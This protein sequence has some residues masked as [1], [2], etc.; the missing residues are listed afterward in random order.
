[1]NQKQKKTMTW[2]LFWTFWGIYVLT[3][4]GVLGMLF[5]GFGAVAENERSTLIQY[6]LVET[7]VA[8]IALFYSLFNLRACTIAQQNASSCEHLLGA[9][10]GGW[11]WQRCWNCQWFIDTNE[12]Q[13]IPYIDDKL[14]LEYDEFSHLFIGRSES[15]RNHQYLVKG[16]VFKDLGVFVYE[17]ELLGVCGAFL[18]RMNP[19]DLTVEGLWM[20]KAQDSVGGMAKGKVI[21]KDCES[22]P[23]FTIKVH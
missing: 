4:I 13:D 2:V 20:G 14:M 6:F 8:L 17:T 12:A 18:V 16:F 15:P 10:V 5:F 19:V 23:K 22:D 11:G 1:M 21:L 3:A 7:S 9:D